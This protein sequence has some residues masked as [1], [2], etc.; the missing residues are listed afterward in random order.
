MGL[1]MCNQYPSRRVLIVDDEESVCEALSRSIQARLGC[2]VRFVL[3]G[4]EA[5]AQLK[6]NSYD[7]VITDMVMGG[8][9]GLELIAALRAE[10]AESHIM[11]MT[12]FPD[13]FP[14][15]DIVRAG[16]DDFIVKPN[17][18]GEIEA[19]VLR[20]FK[21]RELREHLALAEEKYR[22]LFERNMNGMLL[23]DR[24]AHTILDANKA[25]CKLSGKAR[26]DLL[27]V[28]LFELVGAA[29]GERLAQGLALCAKGGQGTLGDISL[30][31]AGAAAACVDV[32][33]TFIE[34]A[35]EAVAL[36]AFTDVT[37]KRTMEQQL[38]AAAIT[39][40]VTGLANRRTFFTRLEWVL[41]Q[42]RR[43]ATPAALMLIDVDNFKHCNDTH[44][45]QAGDKVLN[46]VGQLIR[47]TI[48][49]NGDEGFRY[50][51]DE[52]AV[53][54][55]GAPASAGAR[56]A[57]RMQS[58]LAACE[59]YGTTLSVGVVDYRE[60][61]TAADFVKAADEALYRAKSL[62]KN[63]VCVE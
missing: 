42:A 59:N 3:N 26:E 36:L 22:S 20:T 57:E 54:L 52:F 11:V 29:E 14:Y 10:T 16:A 39:D 50:G 48:R 24:D 9:H 6:E 25:F 23:I 35:G 62:G 1:S 33:I 60:G 12:G 46:T 43:G 51:G 17:Y 37:D 47:M 2:E 27:G 58:A 34:A 44:G 19:K 41:A 55:L 32:S 49:G 61:M 7:I 38:A 4:S 21:E 45:H 63:A 8:L 13:D 53:L 15:V 5:V 28:S 30:S 40:E 18:P 31:R 56:V